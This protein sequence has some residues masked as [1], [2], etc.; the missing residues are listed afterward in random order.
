MP[1][2]DLSQPP[3]ERLVVAGHPLVAREDGHLP[4]LYLNAPLQAD[5]PPGDPEVSDL[6]AQWLLL[7]Q[8]PLETK[9]FR[10]PRYCEE[11]VI[12]LTG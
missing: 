8:K 7:W 11:A 6:G 3:S 1:G 9:R 5:Q 10:W 2:I 12:N 4:V